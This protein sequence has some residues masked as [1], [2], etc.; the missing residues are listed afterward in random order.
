MARLSATCG[1]PV[2]FD[3]EANNSYVVVLVYEED[4]YSIIHGSCLTVLK[5]APDST[6]V[7]VCVCDGV[8]LVSSE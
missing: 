4:H 6:G 7:Y 8:N 3:R 1:K 5:K 2:T